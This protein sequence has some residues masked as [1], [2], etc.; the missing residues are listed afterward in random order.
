[1]LQ[2][3]SETMY[4]S[5]TQHVSRFRD[6]QT[7][8]QYT[9]LYLTAMLKFSNAQTNVKGKFVSINRD[10]PFKTTFFMIPPDNCNEQTNL[11]F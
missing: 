4:L 10:L 6:F 8:F 2:F 5:L 1:M 11:H 3:L 7:L 9:K